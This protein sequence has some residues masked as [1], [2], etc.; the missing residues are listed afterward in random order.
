[1]ATIL[2]YAILTA[3]SAIFFILFATLTNKNGFPR[4]WP[5]VG[6]VPALISNSYNLL[7]WATALTER[8]G[9]TMIIKG[10]WLFGTDM[11]IT[12]DPANVQYTSSTKF[13][14][15]PRGSKSKEFF[16]V[17]GVGHFNLEADEW[18]P[19]RR[20]F[21]S[22]FNHKQ[23]AA[24]S[25]KLAL[26]KV[27]KGLIP[28]LDKVAKN[29]GTIDLQEV[30]QRYAYDL[31]HC[32]VIGHDPSSLSIQWAEVPFLKAMSVAME[33]VFYRHFLPE[34]VWKLQGFLGVGKEKLLMKAKEFLN[35]F[36]AE[37]VS[38]KRKDLSKGNG[39]SYSILTTYLTDEDEKFNWKVS[40][41]ALVGSLLALMLAGKDTTSSALSWFFW[42][43]SHH[44]FVKH[45]IEE[46]LKENT[47]K[48]KVENFHLFTQEELD[49]L[50]YLHAALCETI[51][52][53]PPVPFQT[54]TPLK[55]DVLP[56]GHHVYPKKSLIVIPVYI[57]G[58]MTA[59]WG[60]DCREFKPERWITEKGEIKHEPSHKFFAFNSGPRI[61]L[62]RELAFTQMK[63]AAA[64]IIH[65][66]NFHMVGEQTARPLKSIIMHMENGLQAAITRRWA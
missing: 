64:A 65:N 61:C 46:E 60:N 42:L 6:T 11:V 4:N 45:K 29:P 30:F 18:S 14:S 63:A 50:V 28:V 41:D 43:V 24:Y 16:D 44:P 22:F 54:R 58:R 49:K 19:H 23:F 10:P 15:Y 7:E 35:R 5:L 57:M 59:V 62:G 48:D 31:T 52:L 2:Y 56:T 33:A 40:N 26:D 3:I 20:I 53:F 21:R 38:M 8:A 36:A 34:G 37:Q 32:L 39:E 66:Y 25:T 1:M 12:A 27:E 55:S 13:S 51:R 47:P 17:F 9:G